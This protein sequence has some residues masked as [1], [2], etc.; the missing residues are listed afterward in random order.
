[1]IKSTVSADLNLPS[2]FWD[3]FA[4]DV[5]NFSRAIGHTPDDACT[6]I[7][8]ILCNLD[9]PQSIKGRTES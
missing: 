7:H 4:K 8:Q 3:H 1:M 9:K 2:F 5:E 6:V